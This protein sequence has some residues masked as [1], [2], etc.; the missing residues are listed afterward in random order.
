MNE[1]IT[2]HKI[3]NLFQEYQQGSPR[4][5]SFGYGD[6][7]YFSTVNS[8]ATA[9]YP[10]LFVTPQQVTYTENTTTYGIQI[11]FADRVNEDL[12]NQ[13]DVVSDMSLEAR[14]F[15]SAIKRGMRTYPNLYDNMEI[16]MPVNGIPFMERFNDHVGGISLTINIDIL[17]DV[18]A[19][20][21]YTV[22]GITYYILY[23]DGNVMTAQNNNNIEKEH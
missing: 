18:N 21:Y 8:G 22:D 12:S 2:F 9:T 20:D 6:I 7:V 15:I 3:L 5:N 10:Y 14:R 17:E 4:L 13:K 23:E 19:C 16:Q 11:I 1:Y